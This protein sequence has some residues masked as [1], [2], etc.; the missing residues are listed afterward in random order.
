MSKKNNQKTRVK[1]HTYQLKR[2]KE[3]QEKKEA[4]SQRKQEA[5]Q[6]QG[7]AAKSPGA[8]GGLVIPSLSKLGVAGRKFKRKGIRLRKNHMV[9]GIRI[10]DASSKQKVKDILAAEEAMREMMVD[11]DADEK[12]EDAAE[13]GPSTSSKTTKKK[14]SK[15]VVLKKKKGKEP[16]VGLFSAPAAMKLD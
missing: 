16:K 4:K 15:K 13:A 11:D 5:E 2:E 3:A 7:A 1:A 14:S 6:Q 9:R 10:K 12:I 8:R